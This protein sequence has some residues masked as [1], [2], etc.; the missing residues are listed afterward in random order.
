MLYALLCCLYV[1][2]LQREKYSFLTSMHSLWVGSNSHYLL[3]CINEY[4]V[5]WSFSCFLCRSF[6]CLALLECLE[7]RWQSSD[8]VTCINILSYTYFTCPAVV[9]PGCVLGR[10]QHSECLPACHSS[11]DHHSR[12]TDL[13]GEITLTLACELVP[14]GNWRWWLFST[15]S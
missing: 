7:I 3:W 2:W 12:F 14:H 4:N 9:Y 6:F 15:S 13:Y 11:V 1:L 5:I 10:T 8:S